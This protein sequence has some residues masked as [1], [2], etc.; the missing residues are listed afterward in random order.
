HEGRRMSRLVLNSSRS[1][2][3]V[4]VLLPIVCF[5]RKIS[6][7]GLT[8]RLPLSNIVRGGITFWRALE[9]TNGRSGSA[10]PAQGLVVDDGRDHV[11]HAGLSRP[12]ANLHLA[13]L[14]HRA[15]LSAAHRLSELLVAQSRR[16]AAHREGD[17]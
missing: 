15:A 13:E 14:R 5:S 6:F 10:S 3:T 16:A 2:S 8:A 17:P 4:T 1:V 7:A 9:G 12:A 11:S